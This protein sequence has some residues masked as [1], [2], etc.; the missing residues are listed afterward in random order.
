M[1]LVKFSALLAFATV[2]QIANAE[3]LSQKT[4]PQLKVPKDI[5]LS[6]T[7]QN[8]KD[9]GSLGKFTINGK[10]IECKMFITDHGRTDT[11]SVR[12]LEY[13]S[14][15][16]L[17]DRH[18]YSKRVVFSVYQTAQPVSANKEGILTC[19]YLV[20]KTGAGELT[21]NDLNAYFKKH[22]TPTDKEMKHFESKARHLE[23]MNSR[24]FGVFNN[25]KNGRSVRGLPIGLINKEDAKTQCE[26][27]S[28]SSNLFDEKNI[29]RKSTGSQN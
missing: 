13:D 21:A 20:K 9:L 23:I 28:C 19:N 24:G 15:K 25:T 5:F 11:F 12:P 27:Q 22:A 29:L 17:L 1:R 4:V 6:G 26:D 10:E 2:T 8:S 7:D 3:V 18:D 14:P 16:V